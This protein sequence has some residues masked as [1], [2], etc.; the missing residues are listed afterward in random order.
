M[1]NKKKILLFTDWYEPG[2]KAGGPIQSCRNFVAA[3]QDSYRIF[4][5]TSDRDLGDRQPYPGI[6]T[7]TWVMKGPEVQVWYAGPGKPGLSEIQRLAREIDPDFVYLNS[8]YSWHFTILPV[9]L[10]LKGRLPGKMIL[11][12]R[13]MLH[14]GAI[15]FKSLKKKLFISL[16]KA[17]GVP[18]RMVF[19]ATDEQER[20]D[21][22][23]YFPS[24]GKVA[25]L[26]NFP[27]SE[28]VV[29][30]SIEKTPGVLRC[31]FVS[32]LAPKKNLLFLLGLLRQWPEEGSLLLTLRGEIEDREYWEKCLA[33]ISLLPSSITV[34]FEGPVPNE[35]VTEVLQ[36]HHIFVL[37]TLGENFGHAIFEALL[38]GKPVL[39]S[40]KT[41]WVQLE[42]KK[43]GHDLP[44]EAA[45]F[46][47]VLRFYAAMD[48]VTYDEWSR[49]AMAF[50]KNIQQAEGLKEEYKTNLFS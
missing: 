27:R 33:V 4:I 14:Q 2:Y 15:R 46:D 31:V 20:K 47:R 12:P 26:A 41:P 44:L 50:A 40:D 36:Q 16:L 11:A 37:P 3:M 17:T 5:I 9:W 45:A 30:R 39:I 23:H 22:L 19:Q 48:Q 8:M 1:S 25:V 38:A 24:A 43:V 28:S 42:P 6:E 35:A 7:D 49:S 13:G 29:R 32:R 18:R 10:K 34:R 21:I